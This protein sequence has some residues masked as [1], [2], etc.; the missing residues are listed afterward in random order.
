MDYKKFEA[1]R[2]HGFAIGTLSSDMAMT[3]ARESENNSFNQQNTDRTSAL[4]FIHFGM[5]LLCHLEIT[6]RNDQM[7]GF[8][9]NMNTQR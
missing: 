4:K 7:Q 8:M 2:C 9:E 6:T 5:S 1:S 3:Q